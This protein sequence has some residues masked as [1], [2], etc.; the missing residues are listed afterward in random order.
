MAL[1]AWMTIKCAALNLPFSGAKGGVRVDPTTLS[2]KE[3]LTRCYTSEI[4]IFIDP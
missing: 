4:G 3:R 1:S 2:V